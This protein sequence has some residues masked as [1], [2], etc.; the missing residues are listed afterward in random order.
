MALIAYVISSARRYVFLLD[1]RVI[2]FSLVGKKMAKGLSTH[3]CD[4]AGR[5]EL[6]PKL[7]DSQMGGQGH[8]AGSGGRAC[9]KLGTQRCGREQTRKPSAGVNPHLSYR[10]LFAVVQ[11]PQATNTPLPPLPNTTGNRHTR[12]LRYT[13]M[14]RMSSRIIASNSYCSFLCSRSR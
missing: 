7:A 3:H 4:V 10:R 2:S 8:N 1:L 6:K 5:P 12:S 9:T 13:R 11:I 14:R